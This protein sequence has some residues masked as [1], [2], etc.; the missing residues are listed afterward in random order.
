MVYYYKCLRLLLYPQ[1]SVKSVNSRI[2]HKC[3]EASGGV[4]RAYQRLHRQ[5]SV[6][7][8]LMALY[9]IFL[10]GLTLI[11]CIWMSPKDMFTI[12]TNND[13]NACSIVLY[14]ITERWPG[15]RKY[16]DA[17]ES[18]KQCVMDS[19]ADGEQLPRKPLVGLDA[20]LRATL[21][22]V[23][24]LHPEGR[25]DFGRMISDMLDVTLNSA[26]TSPAVN[27]NGNVNGNT[28]KSRK[29]NTGRTQNKWIPGAQMGIGI[30][31]HQAQAMYGS[32]SGYQY[33]GSSASHIMVQQRSI[34]GAAGSFETR[35]IGYADQGFGVAMP[36]TMDLLDGFDM[37][38][39]LSNSNGFREIL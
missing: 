33:L 18:I 8:S 39:F 38:N 2:L 5:T 12:S 16:R 17:F 9:S 10:A 24:N 34:E 4:C 35:G 30:A 3:A 31:D 11:Y 36:T 37:E 23:Q 15:A 21:E 19:I 13:L 6:G 28:N 29:R 22:D 26:A 1:L 20:G 25:E 32:G 14:V 27:V 7:F